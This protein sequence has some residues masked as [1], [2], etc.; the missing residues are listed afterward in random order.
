[1]KNLEA[2]EIKKKLDN[3]SISILKILEKRHKLIIP[4]LEEI[5]YNSLGFTANKNKITGISLFRSGISAF[6][7]ELLH[8]SNLKI[9]NLAWNRIESLPNSIYKLKYLKKIDLIGNRIKKIPKNLHLLPNLEEC[10]LSF[11]HIES[12]PKN[13]E[14]SI[15]L[16]LLKLIRNPIEK[17]I[18]KIDYLNHFGIKILL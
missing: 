4:L 9:L 16:K 2:E 11:N 18:D 14:K 1:M 8:L 15:S 12:I 17:N 13:L 3:K 6:P 10:D 5:K 7:K